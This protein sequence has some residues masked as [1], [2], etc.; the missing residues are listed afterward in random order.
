MKHIFYEALKDTSGLVYAEEQREFAGRLHFHRAFELAYILEGSAVYNIEGERICAQA[1]DI[2]FVHCFYRHQSLAEPTHSKY[3]IAVPEN[4]TSDIAE[5]FKESTL[6]PLLCHK[7]FNKTLLTYFES[8][9]NA[10]D[11][12][13]KMLVKGY[14]NVIFGSLAEHYEKTDIKQKN[15]NIS[16]IEDILNYIDLHYREPITLE[17]I[18]GYFGYN[19]TYFSRLFNS[20]IGMSLSNYINMIRYDKFDALVKENRNANV[21]E[22]AF[23]CGF[24]SMSTFYRTRNSR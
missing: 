10:G 14:A 21:T 24:P 8:L 15:K 7:E 4:I 6:S 3:V 18:S 17:S 11:N 1:G 2:V 19:K 23:K 16:I 22:L 9:V 5:L 12:T 20:H 13:P